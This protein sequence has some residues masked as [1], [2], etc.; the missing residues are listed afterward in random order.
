MKI[1]ILSKSAAWHAQYNVAANFVEQGG[2]F[3]PW[4]R[5]G[6]LADADVI[7][8]IGWYVYDLRTMQNHRDI[9][10]LGKPTV[11]HWAGSDITAIAEFAVESGTRGL[12]EPLLSKN[13]IHFAET[14]QMINEVLRFGVPEVTLCPI[15]SRKQYQPMP[16]P[17]KMNGEIDP[18]IS[19]YMP[20]Q[21]TGFFNYDTIMAVAEKIPDVNFI[22]YSLASPVGCRQVSD[23]VADWGKLGAEQMD[24]LIGCTNAHIR[25]VEHD[26]RS[27]SV[28][29]NCMAGRRVIY[30]Q[31]APHTVKV[32]YNID[33]IVGAVKMV[34]EELEPDETASEYYIKNYGADAHRRIFFEKVEEKGWI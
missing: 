15:A 24:E 22:L 14:D 28:I 13:V 29:E 20:P 6:E 9:I 12:L 34:N 16:L 1:A 19:V 30:N 31:D 33:E 18:M 21:R 26:G 7:Y 10:K 5:F 2:R 3:V 8:L 27:L 11:I 25:I 4:G 17:K 23:N 32:G